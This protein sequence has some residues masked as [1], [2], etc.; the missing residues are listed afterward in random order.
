[1]PF[2]EIVDLG[3]AK[4][5]VRAMYERQQ[6][7][8]GY[9]PNYAKV[10]SY[11]P[12]ILKLWADLLRGIRNHVDKRRF[13]LV[14]IAAA[15]ELRN[16][17]CSLAHA[18]ALAVFFSAD[19]MRKLMR[20]ETDGLLTDA[21]LAMMEL[22]RKVIRDSS[23]VTAADISRLKGH[24]LSAAEIFDIIAV[25]AGRAFFAKL[26]E[27]LGAEPDSTYLEMDEGLRRDLTFVR[28][29]DESEPQRLAS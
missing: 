22:A 18:K 26:T 27:A 16:T 25:A 2:I 6:Q 28:Q 21:E 17:Y 5:D 23:S 3:A 8:Y 9:V 1:M 14:T 15:L 24:G 19:D 10:F 12:D 20:G 7:A 4:G 11:R 29:I 13:E